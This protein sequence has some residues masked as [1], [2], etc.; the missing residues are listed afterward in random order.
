MYR[1]FGSFIVE[2]SLVVHGYKKIQRRI[3]NEKIVL[4]FR[5]YF[6]N[7]IREHII[8]IFILLK[9]RVIHISYYVFTS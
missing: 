9:T 7:S 4:I 1:I 8:H 6:L 2:F 5:L 3:K